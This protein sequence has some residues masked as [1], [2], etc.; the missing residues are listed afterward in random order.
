MKTITITITVDDDDYDAIQE[1]IARRQA[2]R[3]LP[4]VD[5]GCLSGR[6]LA[7]ICRGWIEMAGFAASPESDDARE[8]EEWKDGPNGDQT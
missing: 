2:W 7:E 4:D 1:A 3:C 8:G 6:L 5:A